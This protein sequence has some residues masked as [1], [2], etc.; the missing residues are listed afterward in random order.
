M[1]GTVEPLDPQEGFWSLVERGL[2]DFAAA[3]L[4]HLVRVMKLKRKRIRYRAELIDGC[5]TETGL[6]MSA[7]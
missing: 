3:D 5:L 2:A 4:D 1:R 6:I 7:G